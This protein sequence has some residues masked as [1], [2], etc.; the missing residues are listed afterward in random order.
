M[1]CAPTSGGHLNSAITIAT[2][3][4]RLTTPCR[5]V[6]YV[7][8]QLTGAIIGGALVRAAAGTELSDQVYQ[9]ECCKWYVLLTLESSSRMPLACIMKSWCQEAVPSSLSVVDCSLWFVTLSSKWLGSMLTV[10]Y[11]LRRSFSLL[12]LLLILD[13]ERLLDLFLD[14]F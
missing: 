10:S 8:S 12:A 2:F 3:A 6:L 4:C 1:A 5:L 13:R 11:P 7:A 9:S 14:P